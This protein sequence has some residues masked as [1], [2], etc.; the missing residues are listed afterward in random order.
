[1]IIYIYWGMDYLIEIKTVE[2]E[3]HH[4]CIY[5]EKITTKI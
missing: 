2:I 3:K 1:M 4:V 5:S